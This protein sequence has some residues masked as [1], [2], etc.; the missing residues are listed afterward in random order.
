MLSVS[1]TSLYL[2]SRKILPIRHCEHSLECVA[3]KRLGRLT[4]SIASLTL[5]MTQELVIV[6]IRKN[7]W[8]AT[9][10]ES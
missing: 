8:Q 10:K 9:S 2:E 3:I 7:A 1:E 6:S 5:A 4:R